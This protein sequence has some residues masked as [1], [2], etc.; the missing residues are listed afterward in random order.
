MQEEDTCQFGGVELFHV[1][2]ND[3]ESHAG[4]LRKYFE[5][6]AEKIRTCVEGVHMC[7]SGV[8]ACM[9]QCVR[10]K[11]RQSNGQSNSDLQIKKWIR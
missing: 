11:D 3:G 1:P 7:G 8:C 4:Q 2:V 5:S 6:V 10:E 9:C